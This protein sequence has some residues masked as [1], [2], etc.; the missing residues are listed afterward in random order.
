MNSNNISLNNINP[1]KNYTHINSPENINQ[2]LKYSNSYQSKALFNSNSN[3]NNMDEEIKT[4]SN[5][6]YSIYNKEYNYRNNQI[7]NIL[8]EIEESKALNKNL[9]NEAKNLN[10][11][12]RYQNIILQNESINNI[13][14]EL[15]NDTLLKYREENAKKL[16]ELNQKQYNKQNYLPNS[17]Q[18]QVE[19]SKNVGNQINNDIYRKINTQKL[20]TI[21]NSEQQKIEN[22]LEYYNK[23]LKINQKKKELLLNKLFGSDYTKTRANTNYDK[24][25]DSNFINNVIDENNSF[26]VNKYLVK[27][28][29]IRNYKIKDSYEKN[30][31]SNKYKF[32]YNPYKVINGIKTEVEKE[33]IFNDTNPPDIIGSFDFQRKHHFS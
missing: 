7:N 18:N 28:N 16:Y 9:L 27:D 23:E 3:L 33:E 5:E 21:L 14:N 8:N 32:V 22:N 31:I 24:D 20:N 6:L 2:N 13:F 10:K 11:S 4:K 29:N 12:D 30:R 15:D 17:L 26:G 19:E 25:N 1:N